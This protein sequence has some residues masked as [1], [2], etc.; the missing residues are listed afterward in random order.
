[1]EN[2]RTGYPVEYQYH[3]S[4]VN[5]DERLHER[6]ELFLLVQKLHGM[7][8]KSAIAVF[9]PLQSQ[10]VNVPDTLFARDPKLANAPSQVVVKLASR[11]RTLYFG[12][13]GAFSLPAVTARDSRPTVEMDARVAQE[14]GIRAN[15]Q[16]SVSVERTPAVCARV[17]VAPLSADDWEV[18]QMHAGFLEDGGFLRQCRVVAPGMVLVIWMQGGGQTVVR[19]RVVGMNPATPPVQRIDN[20]TEIVVAPLDRSSSSKNAKPS[21][22]EQAIGSSEQSPHPLGI[23]ARIIRLE[24]VCWNALAHEQTLFL[25]TCSLQPTLFRKYDLDTISGS[26]RTKKSV[27]RL[28][29]WDLYSEGDLRELSN[30]NAAATGSGAYNVQVVKSDVLPFGYLAVGKEMRD[31]LKLFNGQRA[32]LQDAKPPTT[33]NFKIILQKVVKNANESVVINSR[34][35]LTQE[36][37][38]VKEFQASM[39]LPDAPRILTSNTVLSMIDSV[40]GKRITVVLR[41]A[42][43]EAVGIDT[44]GKD[45]WIWSDSIA[46]AQIDEGPSK[47]RHNP[48]IPLPELGGIKKYLDAL[49]RHVE[50]RTNLRELR[51]ETKIPQL[52]GI[53]VY[54]AKGVGK[55]S[56]VENILQIF[57]HDVN[58][59]AYT[60]IVRCNDLKNKKAAEIK[61]TL[62][63]SFTIS[64]FHS[65]SLL[66]LDDL[67]TVT[68][69]GAEHA[70]AVQAH[71]IS[72]HLAR[73]IDQYCLHGLPGA[74]TVI[75]TAQDKATVDGK[76][77]AGHFFADSV[78]IASPGRADRAEI[79]KVLLGDSSSNVDVMR[80]ATRTEG[81]RPVDLETLVARTASVSAS[82]QIERS[83]QEPQKGVTAEDLEVAM[84][85]YVPAG[86][87]G[88]KI[89]GDSDAIG[90]NDI[91]G[92]HEAKRILI[93]TLEW[94][95]KYAPI[96]ATCPLRLRSGILLYGHPGCGKTVLAAAVAKECGLNFISVKG[97]EVLNKYI[98]ESEKGIRT[99]FDRAQS[100][101][102]CV[103][104]F[105]EFESLAPRRGS[106]NTGVTDRVVNQLLTQL[107]GAEGLDAGVYVLAAT[108]RPDLVDPALLRPGRLDKSVLCGMPEFAERLEI[109]RAV[110]GARKDGNTKITLSADVDLESVARSCEGFSG[111]DLQGLVYS[112]HLAAVH[113]LIESQDAVLKENSKGKG[114]ADKGKVKMNADDRENDCEGVVFAVLQPQG[115]E[116]TL[117]GAER[118]ALKHQVQSIRENVEDAGRVSREKTPHSTVAVTVAARHFAAASAETRAS[119]SAAERRRLDQVYA[120]YSG[121]DMLGPGMISWMMDVALNLK[122]KLM[123]LNSGIRTS[124]A[125]AALFSAADADAERRTRA[126]RVVVDA[127]AGQL[128][129]TDTVDSGG[130]GFEADFAAIAPFYASPTAP[131]FVLVRLDVAGGGWLLVLY[132]P[133]AAR[134]RDKMLYASCRAALVRDLG[135]NLFVDSIHATTQ[136]ECSLEGYRAHERHKAADAPLTDKEQ[137]AAALKL[138]ET[139]ADIGASTRREIAVGGGGGGSGGGVGFAFSEAASS[140]VSSLA[141]H[142]T[143]ASNLVVLTIDAASET[144]ELAAAAHDASAFSGFAQFVS[145]VEPYFLLFKYTHEY[146]GIPQE[147]VLFFYMYLREMISSVY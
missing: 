68:P 25:G 145:D 54:G 16:F 88:L 109:L 32:R 138:T 135:D 141:T 67:D 79:L 59:L 146:E 119:L 147:P 134:V 44:T 81:Y 58:V 120:E 133:D 39:S 1:M 104:F 78:A 55:T 46:E 92:L 118:N 130:Q 23:S 17:D 8:V 43:A 101:K 80:A 96:F 47:S 42:D 50:S 122:N 11:T 82:R 144:I 95:T 45:A 12:W 20:D 28:L 10:L 3:R 72:R 62:T 57:S 114:N 60:H 27:Y 85:S 22:N 132:V 83:L 126:I 19:L 115:L 129:S 2:M 89:G 37:G 125:L 13:T 31:R 6:N 48:E 123:S 103:L 127:E 73:L 41:I 100:A 117:V 110:C 51:N 21:E 76:L 106:D 53:M 113:E 98:G 24:D 102:P 99:L 139:G 93:E 52:G 107:D 75:A 49:K 56:I 30:P 90:W 9:K 7:E 14:H 112:A 108:S 77:F 33:A 136:Y 87:K 35:S 84:E 128:V 18:V 40:D 63:A 143:G 26:N 4:I 140:A 111:A 71:V 91:G 34:Q 66:F 36:Q 5:C 97:P 94:P 116:N 61:K 105:D 74:V 137:D 65:P 86:L 29:A 15:A 64:Q 142:D 70:A 69:A 124:P 121:K 131:C 38:L